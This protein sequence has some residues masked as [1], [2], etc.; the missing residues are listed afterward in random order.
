MRIYIPLIQQMII[1]IL[2]WLLLTR[3]GRRQFHRIGKEVR[4]FWQRQKDGK[5][6]QWHP[7]TPE[8]CPQ[9]CAGIKL[10]VARINQ[11]VNPW[12]ERKGQGGA[13]KK[14]STGGLACLNPLCD[15][16]GIT[17]S[18]IHALVQDCYRGKDG[19]ILQLKCQCCQKRFSSRKGTPLY[20]LKKKSKEVEM[21]LWFMAKGVDLSVMG[22]YTGFADATLA[23]WLN[24]AGQH[25]S[26]LHDTLFRG[27]VIPLVQMDELYARRACH[28]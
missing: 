3:V 14:S 23:R 13:R 28:C 12:S 26:R 11:Q 24:K 1:F 22:R 21:V 10:Q 6:R 19:D 15:Y 7:K 8:D 9:C 4:H 17:K 18:S 20:H 16:F 5:L 25:S 27:L 2:L